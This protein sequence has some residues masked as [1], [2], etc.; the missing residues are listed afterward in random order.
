MRGM[1]KGEGPNTQ[2]IKVKINDLTNNF[3]N[4]IFHFLKFK[5]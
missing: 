5:S 1:E 2:K 3:D 4:A